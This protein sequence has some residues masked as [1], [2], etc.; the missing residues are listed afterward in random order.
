MR[1]LRFRVAALVM[2]GALAALAAG[3]GGDLKQTGSSGGSDG[4]PA[5]DTSADAGA[6]TIDAGGGSTPA[7]STAKAPKSVVVKGS[8][9]RVVK[10]RLHADSPLV[11]TA[12]NS[13]S[14]NFIVDLIGPGGNQNLYN[15]I[16][17]YKGQA[18]WSDAA[19]G[20]YKLKVDAEGSWSI[21]LA[22]PVPPA[23]AITLPRTIKGRG[24]QVIP[25]HV[26][27]DMQPTVT[28]KNS[29]SSN[30]IVDLVGYVT[31][32]GATNVFNEIG[33]WKGQTV[34]DDVPSGDYLLAVQ[35]VGPWSLSFVK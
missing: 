35:A 20:G 8:G 15:E 7:P 10:V 22:Q 6:S 28:G 2:I 9:A 33:P 24:A 34:V 14:S 27:D 21:R 12:S 31:T 13:G 5:V 30:F 25:I 4:A 17:P 18:I 26:S 16:G 11:V 29:G 23:K 3:C 32:S 19:K 1:S